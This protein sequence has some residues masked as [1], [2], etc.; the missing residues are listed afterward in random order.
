MRGKE[1]RASFRLGDW[2]VS[3]DASTSRPRKALVE[4][5]MDCNLS[6]TYCFRRSCAERFGI[7][8]E[9]VFE[10]SLRELA[11][12]GVRR[13][14]LTGWGEPL[15]HPNILG[16]VEI[17]KDLGLEVVVNTNG[18]LLG[19]MAE[20]LVRLGVDEVVVS[21]DAV[22]PEIYGKL[23]VP[24]EVSDVIHGL[25]ELYRAC[26][27]Y[28]RAVVLGLEFTVTNLNY[29][30]IPKVIK[31]ANS[32][33]AT[34]VRLSNVIPVSEEVEEMACYLDE[35]C[36]GLVEEYLKEIGKL[37]LEYRVQ[38]FKVNFRLRAQRVCPFMLDNA[39]FVGWDGA[40]SPCLHYAHSYSIHLFGIKRAI[41]RVTFGNL[42]DEE[43][44]RIW[45][46]P[47]YSAFR[48]RARTGYMPSCLDCDVA[49]YCT[50]T[51]SNL[52]DCW[53]Q[54]PTCSHCPFIYGLVACPL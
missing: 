32:V 14:V 8:S 52:M 47:S 41:S 42:L 17:A 46:K 5:T 6:C 4:V 26:I 15:T 35:G 21:I 49:N 40:V 27:K 18:T 24:G 44:A 12:Q 3:L 1:G 20:D 39:L 16:F 10:R 30:E 53:G 43:L 25:R 50:I 11:T 28:G 45:W 37:A 54:S 2:V 33:K 38:V 13:I 34:Y 48:F 31:L 23:R 22:A 9:R 36:A 51:T 29:A 7:M 19:G